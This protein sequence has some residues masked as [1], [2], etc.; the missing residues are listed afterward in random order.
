MPRSVTTRVWVVVGTTVAEV[1]VPIGVVVVV[2]GRVVGFAVTVEVG[3]GPVV[4][5]S[6]ACILKYDRTKKP[7]QDTPSQP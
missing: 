4:V 5:G 6:S 3:G 1:V 7:E 2:T